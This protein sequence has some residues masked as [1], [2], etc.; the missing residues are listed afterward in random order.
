MQKSVRQPGSYWEPDW[1]KNQPNQ[2]GHFNGHIFVWIISP[3][4]VAVKTLVSLIF[5]ISKANFELGCDI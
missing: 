3:H 1:E 2:I 4:S 5:F